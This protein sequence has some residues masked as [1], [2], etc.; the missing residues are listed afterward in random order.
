MH[1]HREVA[2]LMFESGERFARPLRKAVIDTDQFNV[3]RNR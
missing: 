3:Q 1:V 2:V